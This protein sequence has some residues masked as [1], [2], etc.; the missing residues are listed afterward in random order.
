MKLFVL[1]Y[2]T[3]VTANKIHHGIYPIVTRLQEIE[4]QELTILICSYLINIVG[5]QKNTN[6]KY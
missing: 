3:T 5:W 2:L 6:K 4:T 1:N